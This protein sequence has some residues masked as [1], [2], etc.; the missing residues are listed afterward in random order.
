MFKLKF[1]SSVKKD[2][3]NFPDH[4]LARIALEIKSLKEDPLPSGVKKIKKEKQTHYRI[5]VGNFRI[6]YFIYPGQ[7][8]IEILYIKRRN[9][10]TY[11]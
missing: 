2:V 1:K 10:S 3:R 6:G 7:N 11:G 9:E 5:R 4:A 8:I